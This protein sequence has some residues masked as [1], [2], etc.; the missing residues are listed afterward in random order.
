MKN[1]VLFFISVLLLMSCA[2]E[3]IAP[4]VEDIIQL[5]DHETFEAEYRLWLDQDWQNYSFHIR[6]DTPFQ[7]GYRDGTIIVKDGALYAY[8]GNELAGRDT[9]ERGYIDSI[10]G[11]YGWV[12]DV[13]DYW[14]NAN[15]ESG[16]DRQRIYK[17]EIKFDDTYH[18]P[19]YY[20][21][22]FYYVYLTGKPPLGE[23]GMTRMVISD[24]TP[25]P[26]ELESLSFDRETFE[27][28]RQLW[29]EQGL[30]DYSF[31]IRC[32]SKEYI[33]GWGKEVRWSGKVVIKDGALFSFSQRDNEGQ[34]SYLNTNNPDY[35]PPPE[36]E[37]WVTAISEI[38]NHIVNDSMDNPGL[39]AGSPWRTEMMCGKE[40]PFSTFSF[41][42]KYRDYRC[43]LT[44]HG[45]SAEGELIE[46]YT[47]LFGLYKSFD[48][49]IYNLLPIE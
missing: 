40:L 39:N 7:P 11:I 26:P 34:W 19:K 4:P 2:V 21:S 41:V 27:R 23:G 42:Y 20:S 43:L 44:Q 29:L 37:K 47:D 22:E 13:Y 16:Q 45:S 28:E 35:P 3:D 1:V 18:F 10:S 33:S 31:K 49:F 15:Y 30:R 6:V 25:N 32:E 9:L 14:A 46:F 48:L 5:V 24:F 12:S 17:Q 38:Y 36:L 8:I